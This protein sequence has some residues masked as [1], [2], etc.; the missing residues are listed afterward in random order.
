V[1]YFS[2]SFGDLM[3]TVMRRP[4]AQNEL[5]EL[6]NAH[7]SED[8]FHWKWYLQDLDALGYDNERMSDAC[9]LLWSVESAP[10]RHLIYSV[11]AYAGKSDDP[12]FHLILIE[13][14]E[15]GLSGFFEYCYKGAALSGLEFLNYF[16]KTHYMAEYAHSVTSWFQVDSVTGSDSEHGLAKFTASDEVR[17]LSQ[18]AIETIFARFDDMYNFW[19]SVAA[20]SGVPAATPAG[21]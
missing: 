8:D 16:G 4:E 5:E 15:A 12:L 11:V 13:I 18:E 14:L 6:V 2:M 21:A 17:R 9:K 20:R 1:A 19:Y 10:V 7:C 3:T